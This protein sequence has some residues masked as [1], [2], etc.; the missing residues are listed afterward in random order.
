MTAKILRF[1]DGLQT[2]IIGLVAMLEAIFTETVTKAAPILAPLPPAFSVYTAMSLRT[3][4]WVAIGTALAIELIGMFSS[5]V[6]VKSWNWNKT[7]IKSEASAPFPLAVAM[8]AVY[9]VVVLA[10]SLGIEINENFLIAIY[11]GF[12]VIAASV[13]VS[14]AVST[15]LGQWQRERAERHAQQAERSGLA[16]DIRQ[17]KTNLASVKNEAAELAETV[18]KLRFERVQLADDI[19]AH[20]ARLKRTLAVQEADKPPNDTN[21]RDLLPQANATRQAKIDDRH[22]AIIE[23]K[24]N[25]PGISQPDLTSRLNELGYSVSLST[26]KRDIKSLN[27]SLQGVK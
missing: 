17:A 21:I 25:E 22:Q 14:S 24:T 8:A 27:G 5:K 18:Q 26:V 15:D 2:V 1:Y 13:Y 20:K 9:F 4:Q 11:P 3:P 23:I 16:A 10:L 7:R 12:V 19:K 6:A